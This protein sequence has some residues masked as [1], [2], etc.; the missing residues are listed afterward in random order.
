MPRRDALLWTAVF[1]PPLAWFGDL[2]VSWGLTPEAGQREHP[3]ALHG[4]T[5]IALAI[6]LSAGL[7]AWSLAR[8]IEPESHDR[9]S[10]RARFLASCGIALASISTL[11]VIGTS[12]PKWMLS[13][14]DEP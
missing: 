2:V 5:L 12:V 4:V 14:G 6:T 10:Q 1:A 7:L 3:L 9:A 8:R 13:P 11:L